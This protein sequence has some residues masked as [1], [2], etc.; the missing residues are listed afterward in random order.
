V[1][2]FSHFLYFSTGLRKSGEDGTDVGTLLHRN[3][4][5][6][7]LLVNPDEECLL[8]VMEDTSSIRPDTVE[9]TG[10][11]ESVSLLEKEVIFNKLTSLAFSH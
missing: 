7:I 11:K 10:L 8:V 4:S 6:L 1:G 9:I 2:E 3:N 5:E